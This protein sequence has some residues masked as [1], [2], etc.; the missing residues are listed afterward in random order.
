VNVNVVIRDDTGAMVGTANTVNLAANG[1][2]AFV[3]SS[4][5]PSTANIRGSLEFDTPPNGQIS[6]MGIRYTPP[7]IITTIP[8]LA[9]VGTAGGSVAQIASGGGWQ[10]SFVL[11]NTGLSLATAQLSFFTDGGTP[12]P[13]PLSAPQTGVTAGPTSVVSTALN[14]DQIL[15]LNSN[16]AAT[17]PVQ[18][19]SAQLATNGNVSGY[20]IFTYLPNG[21]Q[22][23]V[24]LESRNASSYIIAYDNTASTV[25]GIALNNAA[26]TTATIPVILRDSNGNQLGTG[27]VSLAANGHSAFILSQQFP[28]TANIQGTVEFDTPAGGSIGVVGLRT[29]PALTFTTLPPMV[30]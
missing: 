23:V 30:R 12:L 21:Q 5:F 7:G 17:D 13:M 25:T 6:V 2:T 10:T 20:V 24:P 8:V 1:Q 3:L 16:A 11:I 18:I 28:A 15:I 9:N 22:A 19:G 27:T 4:Q 14:P 29:P 26:T